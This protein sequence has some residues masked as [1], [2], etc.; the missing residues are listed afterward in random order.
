MSISAS[1]VRNIARLA[2]LA[3]NESEIEPLATQLSTI[4]GFV[5][6]MNSVDTSEVEPMA[7]PQDLAAR[8]R[9]DL[10][11]ETDKRELYQRGAPSTADGQYLV[12]QVIE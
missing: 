2:R 12:P 10:V 4:L 5:E 7:H 11:T 6:Q 8:L 3:V 9:D 1:E